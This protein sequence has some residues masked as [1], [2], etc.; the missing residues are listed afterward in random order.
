MD[1]HFKSIHSCLSHI[2]DPFFSLHMP[3]MD[4]SSVAKA[5]RNRQTPGVNLS[6]TPKC[7]VTTPHSQLFVIQ[8]KFDENE[9]FILK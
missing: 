7:E 6:G 4:D 5:R 8:R 2:L 3:G 1:S 9:Y